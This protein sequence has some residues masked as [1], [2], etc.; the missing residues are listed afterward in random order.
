MEQDDGLDRAILTKLS[1]IENTLQEGDSRLV[2]PHIEGQHVENPLIVPGYDH[3]QIDRRLRLLLQRGLI[4]THA[5]EDPLI[6]IFFSGLTDT[7]RRAL[8]ASH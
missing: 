7:G 5:N 3:D 6:G 2:Q 1:E 8:R 4:H